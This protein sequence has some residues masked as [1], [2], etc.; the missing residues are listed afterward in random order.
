M[1]GQC[2][3]LKYE[4]TYQP[5]GERE[6]SAFYLLMI[7]RSLQPTGGGGE[8][9]SGANQTSHL[10]VKHPSIMPSTPCVPEF[11]IKFFMRVIFSIFIR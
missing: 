8:E 5:S 10:Q 6:C 7:V 9:G 1:L 2:C 3:S 4:G 11:F